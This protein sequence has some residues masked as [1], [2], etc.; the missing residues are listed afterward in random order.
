[1]DL[2]E[3]INSN[4]VLLSNGWPELQVCKAA[5]YSLLSGGKRI[6]PILAVEAFKVVGGV[7]DSIMPYAC[8]LEFVHTSSLIQDDLMDNHMMRRGQ[9]TCYNLYGLGTALMA[10]QFICAEAYLL[11]KD[12][13]CMKE[14]FLTVRDMCI[15]QAEEIAEKKTGSLFRACV[16]IGAIVGGATSEQ[17][18]ALSEYGDTIGLAFQLRDDMLDQERPYEELRLDVSCLDIFGEKAEN[19]R[20]IAR[21][22]VE[23]TA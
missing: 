11:I 22:I 4:L 7:G 8:A 15:G 18:S 12:P 21:F 17:L 5:Q 3:R 16:H 6:R 20:Q 23:R 19:L 2:L 14:L 9:P 10:S 1:M 13:R